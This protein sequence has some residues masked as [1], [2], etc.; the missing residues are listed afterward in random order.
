V[1]VAMLAAACSGNSAGSSAKTSGAESASFTFA[2]PAAPISLDITKDFDGNIMQ[3]MALVTEKLERIS[4]TGQLS[5]DLATSV[6]QPNATTLIYHIRSGVRLSDGTPLTAADVAWSLQHVTDTKAGAQTAGNVLSFA[7]AAVT[8]PL[9]VTV[10]LKYPDPT[11]RENLSVISFIQEAKFGRAHLSDLGSP[12]VVPIGTGP[13]KVS[14]DTTQAVT[15]TRNPYYWGPKPPVAKIVFNFISTDT[16]AQLAMRSGSIQGA[17]VGDLKTVSA[18]KAIS[19]TTLYSL[20]SLYTNFLTLD[21]SSGPL[22]DVHVRKAIAYSL[23]RAGVMAA[24]F[25][26]YATLMK[27]LATAGLLADVAPSAAA[28]QSFLN[29]LPQYPFDLAKARAELAQS[30]YPHGF[31]LTVPY[32]TADPASELT[33]L[34]LQQNMKQLGV[35]ITPKAESESQWTAAIYAHG[36]NL[37]MQTMALIPPIPDPAALLGVVTGT[38]NI[39][40]QGFNLA[41][42]SSPA[43]N[44]ANT[45]LN[46]STDKATRWHAAETLLSAIAADVPYIP[47]YSQNTVA[48]L[49]GGW[50]FDTP[51]N[52]FDLD[53]DGTWAFHLAAG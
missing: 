11:A 23:D 52:L 42:W 37:G 47:L 3:I 9:Q 50:R 44:Q 29:G 1:A 46:R 7:S 40:P 30:A 41:N 18:W 51:Q 27:G 13:Y 35:T 10:K 15:L 32:V 49:G 17:L 36:K 43:V 19:G 20:P 45:E 5:P 12:G 39:R 16:T 6:T 21:M 38:E 31:S 26:Q 33:V 48:V 34:N 24:G 14:S 25:G 8:G 53:V 4:N 2:L 28:A 22:S